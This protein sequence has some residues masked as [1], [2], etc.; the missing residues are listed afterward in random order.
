MPKVGEVI[1]KEVAALPEP[2][3]PAV[4]KGV[5][6]AV[7][8]SEEA[9]QTHVHQGLTCLHAGWDF[10][11]YRHFCAALEKDPRCLMAHWGAA[12]SLLQSTS[13]LM[14]ER[15]AALDRMLS[16]VDQGAGTDLERRYCFAL[17]MLLRDGAQQAAGEF[18]KLAEEFPNDPQVAFLASL[19]GR[20]GYSESGEITPDQEREEK[21]V[22]ELVAK[23]PGVPYLLYGLLAMRAEAPD[24][25]DDLGLARSL[26]EQSPDFPPFHH[27]LG[28]YEWKCGNL[29]RSAKA[30]ERAA[31]LYEDW[32]KESGT[33]ALQ[34][35]GWTKAQSYRAAA[36]ASKGDYEKALALAE[37]VAAVEVPAK[38]AKSSGAKML[39][40]E[41]R[42]LPI[43]ILMRRDAKGDAA[44]ALKLLPD[45]EQTKA[46]GASSLVMWYYQALSSLLAGR[47]VTED[48]KLEDARKV[49]Q[50]ITQLG[51][52]FVK[53]RAA[54]VGLGERSE[55]LRSFKAMEVMT[56]ELL[57]MIGM[58]G[59]EGPSVSAASW[60]RSAADHQ[61]GATL[62]MPP[63]VLLPMEVRLAQ[64]HMEKKEWDKAIEVLT[65]GLARR[66]GDVELLSRLQVSQE[67]A[68]MKDEAADTAARIKAIRAD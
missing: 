28:H 31:E 8:T 40:W 32:M 4:A 24:L 35:P 67:N 48:G 64:Y 11:A 13:D 50:N 27:L 47:Q 43:R 21:R 16:L 53:T 30:F 68:G 20:G 34:C 29:S 7:T 57:G 14:D 10:E 66:P 62:M 15:N 49:T 65:E 1:S 63:A 39:L 3:P 38:E 58:A 2:K 26:C 17:V 54:A 25:Q 59:A 46:Y 33:T 18:L 60:F 52:T 36:L 19:L 42:T 23:N 12:M 51:E 9:A 5:T 61:T 45:K 56:A 44:K 37:E 22:R 55:W 6:M 41:G